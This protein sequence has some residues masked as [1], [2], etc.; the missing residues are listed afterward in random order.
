MIK[1]IEIGGKC[2]KKKRGE[3]NDYLIAK[4]EKGFSYK[5]RFYS[6]RDINRGINKRGKFS[7]KI[8]LLLEVYN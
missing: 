2:W 8:H 7:Y 1:N 4:K 5:I 3:F 6:C